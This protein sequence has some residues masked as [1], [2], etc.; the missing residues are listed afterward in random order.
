MLS[1]PPI[2]TA[3]HRLYLTTKEIKDKTDNHLISL[4]CCTS[5]TC[6]NYKLL[7]IFIVFF[8]L[9]QNENC[10][11]AFCENQQWSIVM[12]LFG[13]LT[14]SVPPNLKAQILLTL[15]A[16]AKTPDIAANLWQTLEVS[17][18]SIRVLYIVCVHNRVTW[19]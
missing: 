10:R 17:Q 3:T 7:G 6:I 15:S 4:T 2:K 13:L 1:V 9:F 18:V 11:I 12:C 8:Y 19:Y 14:C 16:F 5:I